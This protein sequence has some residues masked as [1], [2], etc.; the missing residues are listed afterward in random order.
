MPRLTSLAAAFA[1][2]IFQS[3]TLNQAPKKF[4]RQVIKILRHQERLNKL[5]KY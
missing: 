3:S 4:L 2:E 1:A 5:R